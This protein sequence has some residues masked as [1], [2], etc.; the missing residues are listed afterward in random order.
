MLLNNYPELLYLSYPETLVYQSHLIK[1]LKYNKIQF[2]Y[3][4]PTRNI[5]DR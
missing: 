3:P 4:S 1:G 2:V 5:C